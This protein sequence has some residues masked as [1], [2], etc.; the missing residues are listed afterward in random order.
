MSKF[1][2]LNKKNY[3]I[4]LNYFKNHFINNMSYKEYDSWLKDLKDECKYLYNFSSNNFVFYI[5]EKHIYFLGFLNKGKFRI[6]NLSDFNYYDKEKIIRY[7][8]KFI[9]HQRK[10][11][12]K[13]LLNEIS[14]Y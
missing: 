9:V 3:D 13:K 10:L 1:L 6:R 12:L 14:I 5:D 11:K 4:Y 8:E 2:I 7:S